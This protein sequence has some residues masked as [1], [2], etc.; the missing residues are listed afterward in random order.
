MNFDKKIVEFCK[1]IPEEDRAEVL[2]FARFL[3]CVPGFREE[4]HALA[5]PG[6]RIP[7][8]DVIE[9]LMEKWKDRLVME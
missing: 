4:L 3:R 7:P 9:A 5:A 8:L 2:T 6:E 1:E